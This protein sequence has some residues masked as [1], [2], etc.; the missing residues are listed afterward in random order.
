MRANP[1]NMAGMMRKMQKMQKEMQKEQAEL[2]TRE[3][4]AA[5]S[6][7]LVKITMTGKRAITDLQID[8]KVIDPEDPEMLQD[9]I[10]QA[11]NQVLTEIETTTEKT[12]GK[13]TRG[14]M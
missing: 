1:G 4:T 5:S 12:M 6:D 14:L 9:L 7:D 2:E 8:P 11:T 3:F 13:Y 10:I